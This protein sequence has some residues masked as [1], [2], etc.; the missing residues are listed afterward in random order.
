MA[1]KKSGINFKQIL[2]QKG[3]RYGFYA[4]SGLLLLFLFLGVFKAVTS[5]ST[6]K[7]VEVFKKEIQTVDQK[8]S[9]QGDQAKPIDPV[10]YGTSTVAQI[11][12]VRIPRRTRCST[13]PSMSKRSA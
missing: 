4:A 2:L 1:K 11:P 8:M 5:A 12:F 13:K 9:R 7:I 6:G 10:V 3:E